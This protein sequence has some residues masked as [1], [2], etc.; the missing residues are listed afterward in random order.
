MYA[1]SRWL[2]IGYR[3]PLISTLTT[4]DSITGSPVGCRALQ[5]QGFDLLQH[6]ADAA[7]DLLALDPERLELDPGTLGLG[8]PPAGALELGA[9]PRV[10][11]GGARL[12]GPGRGS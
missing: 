5:V 2:R 6:V 8:E 3:M 4:L 10:L 12:L 7:A 9:K 1:E 11:L